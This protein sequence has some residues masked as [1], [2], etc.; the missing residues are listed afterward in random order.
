M[1]A[2]IYSFSPVLGSTMKT[3]ITSQAITIP[4][5]VSVKVGKRVVIVKGPR[6]TLRRS[7]KDMKLDIVVRTTVY[8][9][10][11]IIFVILH[12]HQNAL[13]YSVLY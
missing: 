10:V 12:L 5:N 1:F 2:I 8:Y 9:F 4:K 13:E 3:I 11:F 7:F 6:G